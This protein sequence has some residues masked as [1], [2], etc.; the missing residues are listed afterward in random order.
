MIC[1]Q[2]FSRAVSQFKT[3]VFLDARKKCLEHNVNVAGRIFSFIIKGIALL[4]IS[5]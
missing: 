4:Y 1:I 5:I 3:G 2:L